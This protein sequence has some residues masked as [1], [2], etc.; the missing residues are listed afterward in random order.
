[1]LVSHSHR[2]VFLKTHKTAGTSL[3]A[4]LRP[5]CMPP[6]DRAEDTR[7]V[8][9]SPWGLVARAPMKGSEVYNPHRLQDHAGLRLLQTFLPNEFHAYHK[10]AVVRHPYDKTVSAFFF[11]KWN[12]EQSDKRDM[13]HLTRDANLHAEFHRYVT[14]SPVFPTMHH[15][16]ELFFHR[17]QF[18]ID[19]IIRF[20]SL[21][22]DLQTLSD[23]L[24]LGLNIA[25]ALPLKKRIVREEVRQRY[26]Q[27]VTPESKAA[28]DEYYGWYFD[29]FGYEKTL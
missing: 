9:I 11:D 18:W 20:E 21:A 4:L 17:E 24:G 3:H 26:R 28:I 16:R 5:F 25:K 23:R 13:L 15:D 14:N 2:F 27:L 7:S 10:I 1:M 22:K 19:S 8:H 12:K 6:Q 29:Q